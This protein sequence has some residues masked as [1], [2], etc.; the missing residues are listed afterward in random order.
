MATRVEHGTPVVPDYGRPPGA[1]AWS[2]LKWGFGILVVLGVLVSVLLPSLCKAREPANR[3][4]CAS[5]LHQIGLAIL[6]YQQ[7]NHRAYPDTL[8]R[9]VEN[10][11]VGAGVFVCPSGN[12]ESSTAATPAEM[13]AD[14]DAGPAKHHCSYVYLGRGLTGD[15]PATT[16]VAYDAPDEHDGDGGNVLFGDGRAEWETKGWVAQALATAATRPAGR[17]P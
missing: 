1:A 3:A 6:L 14:I 5:N 9:L 11:Q 17:Q 2:A 12:E 15:V 16:I 7:D 4:K 10:E 13:A 8:G